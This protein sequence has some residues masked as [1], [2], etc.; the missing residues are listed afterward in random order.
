MLG[1]GTPPGGGETFSN[2]T[3]YAIPDR[4]VV[5]S[6]VAVSGV[7]G[8]APSALKVGVDIRHTYRG[9]LVIDLIAPNGTA[10]RLK[11]SSG[12]D[13]ADNVIETYTVNASA[14][15]VATG[16]WHLRVQ[17]VATID[18]GYISNVTLTF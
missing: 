3:D 8:A 17:D 10:F 6:P 11:N 7:A 16:T 14:V 4:G 13:S 18:T 12:G 2:T 1:G 5:S 9:D 15:P